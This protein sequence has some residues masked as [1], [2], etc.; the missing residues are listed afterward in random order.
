MLKTKLIVFYLKKNQFSNNRFN[1]LNNKNKI[2]IK[3]LY[4]FTI[5]LK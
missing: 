2:T 1:I 4:L 5:A 3:H